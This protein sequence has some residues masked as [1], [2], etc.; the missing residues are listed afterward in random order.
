M[1]IGYP[2]YLDVMCVED[3]DKDKIRLGTE[4]GLLS[5]PLGNTKWANDFINSF[6]MSKEAKKFVLA[7]QIY[8]GEKNL[9]MVVSAQIAVVSL[10]AIASARWLNRRFDLH[11]KPKMHNILFLRLN[12]RGMRFLNYFVLATSYGL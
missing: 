11:G 10:F 7:R 8:W 9:P 4:S 3:V 5:G 12:N 2:M 1:L 6:V